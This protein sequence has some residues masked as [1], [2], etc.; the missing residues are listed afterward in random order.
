VVSDCVCRPALSLGEAE[1]WAEEQRSTYMGS[2]RSQDSVHAHKY[3]ELLSSSVS[4]PKR[5]D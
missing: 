1:R 5:S 2:L 4:V 3:I